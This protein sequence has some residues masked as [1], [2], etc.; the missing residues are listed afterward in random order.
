MHGMK[1]SEKGID[2]TE[3]TGQVESLPNARQ[4]RRLTEAIA[5]AKAKL[6]DEAEDF[7]KTPIVREPQ[8]LD[9]RYLRRQR[10]LTVSMRALVIATVILALFVITSPL[11]LGSYSRA[12]YWAEIILGI[13]YIALG[14][15][16]I[17]ICA[18]IHARDSWLRTGR[19]RR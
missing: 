10:M 13:S 19:P 2:E 14:I 6:D 18:L 11:H 5:A 1:D 17:A 16:V 3:K 4:A 15:S 7:S 9:R 8:P 12:R